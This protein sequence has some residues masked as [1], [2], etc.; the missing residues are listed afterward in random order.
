VKIWSAEEVLNMEALKKVETQMDEFVKS[1][2]EHI[3][4]IIDPL[5][6][7]IRIKSVFRLK[8]KF[9]DI[10]LHV[11]SCYDDDYGNRFI[12]Y[13]V[14]LKYKGKLILHYMHHY[15]YGTTEAIHIYKYLSDD[16][17]EEL[18]R[19]EQKFKVLQEQ[20]NE[21]K[22]R[23]ELLKKQAWLI[24]VFGKTYDPIEIG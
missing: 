4:T 1:K 20:T 23:K 15:Y 24:E 22:L 16:E 7:S 18:V 13:E 3:M 14:W 21:T 11:K 17:Y 8:A 2:E 5:I 19:F 12:G 10:Y 9:E 6:N